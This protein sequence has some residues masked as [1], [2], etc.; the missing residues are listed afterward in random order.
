MPW[1]W[2]E[3]VSGC[4]GVVGPVIVPALAVMWGRSLYRH[5]LCCGAG[6]CTGTGCAVG[7]V[8]VP[9]LAEGS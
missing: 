7:P 6:H 5:W 8:I 4:S 2:A 9:A 1:V 3:R